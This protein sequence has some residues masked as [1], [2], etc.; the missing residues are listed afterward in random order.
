MVR[1][2]ADRKTKAASSVIFQ[3][4]YGRS[5]SADSDATATKDGNVNTSKPA[6]TEVTASLI[7]SIQDD[8]I[9]ALEDAC[10]NGDLLEIWEINLQ[11]QQLR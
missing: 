3:T 9:D 11:N 7:L 1:K 2:Y 5:L 6:S 8:L 10:Q 4:D